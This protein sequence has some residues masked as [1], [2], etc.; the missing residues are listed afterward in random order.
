MNINTSHT[1]FIC[2]D[3]GFFSKSLHFDDKFHL[4]CK[5]CHGL[6]I[7]GITEEIILKYSL[8]LETCLNKTQILQ[9]LIQSDDSRIMNNKLRKL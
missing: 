9:L 7:L 4:Y 2:Q 8:D 1:Y 5:K 3:C 6:K